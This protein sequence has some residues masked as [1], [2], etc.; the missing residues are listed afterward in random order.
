M[1]LEEAVTPHEKINRENELV[2]EIMSIFYLL[3]EAD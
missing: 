1:R 2:Y 3:A